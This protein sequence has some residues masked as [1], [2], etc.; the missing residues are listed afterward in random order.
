MAIYGEPKNGDFVRYIETLNRQTG[1][2]GQVLPRQ[3]N[4]KPNARPAETTQADTPESVYT[5]APRN[6]STT[7]SYSPDSDTSSTAY[8]RNAS[9]G[10][11]RD[12]DDE[13]ET[14]LAARSGQRHLSLGLGIAGAIALWNA[15]HRLITAIN[16]RSLD[17]D[18]MVP[19]VFLSI[20]AWMLFKGARGARRKQNKPLV[21]LPPLTTV[22]MGRKPG[23]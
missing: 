13:S 23:K 10:A 2:P 12:N 22:H 20:C 16:T 3:R 1:S 21:K 9:P 6:K 4:A 8:T 19:I 17:L 18:S 14:T 15:V 5:Y 11:T 7:P